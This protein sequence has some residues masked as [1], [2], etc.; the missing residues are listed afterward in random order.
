[1]NYLAD[2]KG[3][4]YKPENLQ[5]GQ[6]PSPA[7]DDLSLAEVGDRVDLVMEKE[8]VKWDAVAKI[9]NI[10]NKIN[11]SFELASKERSNEKSEF[12]FMTDYKNIKSKEEAK[13]LI[14]YLKTFYIPKIEEA[15]NFVRQHS[16][17]I[18]DFVA[19][20]LNHPLNILEERIRKVYDSANLEGPDS[21]LIES[22]YNAFENYRKKIFNQFV[23]I[24]ELVNDPFA[25]KEGPF[26]EEMI[27]H[28]FNAL[29]VPAMPEGLINDYKNVENLDSEKFRS[30]YNIR[31]KF[32]IAGSKKTLKEL[33]R[34]LRERTFEILQP[35]AGK[36]R[37]TPE[38]LLK[39]YSI[40]KRIK[41]EG[42][43]KKVLPTSTTTAAKASSGETA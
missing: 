9:A 22:S 25:E 24:L 42:A 8:T 31:M 21:K 26:N 23:H 1:M 29:K 20:L 27:D 39:F 34:N 2:E 30:D 36:K 19:S 14:D 17:I 35:S 33:E 13:S 7:I 38:T 28:I 6:V 43:M 40:E 5:E 32:E 4:E 37:I 16:H 18:G 15:R 41:E 11:N 10:F 3:P 12:E